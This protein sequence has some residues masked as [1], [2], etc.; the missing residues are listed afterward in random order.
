MKL[1]DELIILPL[2]CAVESLQSVLLLEQVFILLGFIVEH[3]LG[4][5]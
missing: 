3:F 4:L 2:E 1:G 5:V